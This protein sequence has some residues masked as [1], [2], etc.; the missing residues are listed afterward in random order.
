[1]YSILKL[2]RIK[3]G[4]IL[5]VLFLLLIMV[6]TVF[7]DPGRTTYYVWV[8]KTVIAEKDVKG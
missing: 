3:T 5:G 6:G 4:S 1:M 7:A 2:K 8:C